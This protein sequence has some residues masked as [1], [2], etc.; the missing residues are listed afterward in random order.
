MF[1]RSLL[2][3]VPLALVSVFSSASVAQTYTTFETDSPYVTG[4]VS[5]D[6]D[7]L[8]D[9]KIAFCNGHTG[10]VTSVS[11][12]NVDCLNGG[13]AYLLSTETGKPKYGRG[14]AY[15]TEDGS[16]IPDSWAEECA[17]DAD[18]DGDGIPNI[19]DK[20]S[21]IYDEN[22]CYDN[23]DNQLC[24]DHDGGDTGWTPD[25][26]GG[27]DLP[28]G[29]ETFTDEC[30]VQ[31]AQ[32]QCADKGGVLNAWTS[33]ISP[34]LT[35]NYECNGE[36]TNPPDNGGGSNGGGDDGGSDGGGSGGDDGG[37]DGGSGDS[38]G[39]TDGFDDSGIVNAI[40]SLSSSNS[41]AIDQLKQS[42]QQALSSLQS[43]VV[44]MNN[45]LATGINGL[46]SELSS[47]NSTASD[48][49]GSIENTNEGI[50]EIN[51]LL[52]DSLTGTSDVS[53]EGVADKYGQGDTAE[54]RDL[55]KGIIQLDQ[56]A[57]DFSYTPSTWSCPQNYT[58]D[59]SIADVEFPISLFCDAADVIY[60]FVIAS[61][62]L[63]SAFMIARAF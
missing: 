14:P 48:I 15:D 60:W 20:D 3:F 8:V 9:A 21:G 43:T 53:F 50:G 40:N 42:N 38:G 52:H 33:G 45:N 63:W 57:N 23:P 19:I 47:L 31:Y 17:E 12:G 26:S 7:T 24:I 49:Q 56:F 32:Q 2:L 44:D 27:D 28:V 55:D 36:N 61:A 11:G 4:Y 16:C 30:C 18:R 29:C 25:G 1:L 34:N 51:Q 10:G 37:S 62:Y 58:L 39:S 54:L 13:R 41:S 6:Y 22:F 35:C 5:G 46:G 59:L